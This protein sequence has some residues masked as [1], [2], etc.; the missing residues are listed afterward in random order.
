MNPAVTS[1]DANGFPSQC[2]PRRTSLPNWRG[3]SSRSREKVDLTLGLKRKNTVTDDYAEPPKSLEAIFSN[4]PVQSGLA[5]PR[6]QWGT[7]Q[8]SWHAAAGRDTLAEKKLA[9]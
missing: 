5:G 4:R 2:A 9:R 3:W 7:R 1:H 6:L 8:I